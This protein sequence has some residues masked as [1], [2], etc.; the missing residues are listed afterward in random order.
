MFLAYSKTSTTHFD[1]HTIQ[2]R[3]THLLI[4]S[5]DSVCRVVVLFGTALSAMGSSCICIWDHKGS[6]AVRV[7]KFAE[8]KSPTNTS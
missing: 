4:R 3:A 8:P 5:W 6:R 2:L 1:M 7:D